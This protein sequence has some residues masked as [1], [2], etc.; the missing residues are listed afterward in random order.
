MD[1]NASLILGGLNEAQREAVT[2]T[3]GPLL[4]VAGPGTGKTL[5]IVRRTAWLIA[6]GVTPESILAVT[7]TNRS[8]R[9]MKERVEVLLGN[10]GA[11]IFIGTLH[12]LGLKIIKKASSSDFTL[13]SREEQFELIKALSKKTDIRARD[14]VERISRIKNHIDPLDEESKGL[15]DE[16][17]AALKNNRAVDFDDLIRTPIDILERNPPAPFVSK[18]THIMIDEYQDINPAQYRLLR[19]LSRTADSIC[20]IGDADQAIYGFRGADSSSFL[21][22]SSDFNNA[23][24]V[25]LTENYRSSGSILSASHSVISRNQKRIEKTIVP[26]LGQGN[27]INVL[28]LPD[29]RT[30]GEFIVQEIE[31]RI[32]GTSHY[33]MSHAGRERG[34][35]SGAFSFSDF[36]VLYRTNAQAKAIEEVFMASGIPYQ[37]VGR[38]SS[39]QSKE[40]EETIA[41]LHSLADPHAPESDQSEANEAKLLTSAD[42]FDPRAN[43]V[44]LATMHTAKGLEFRVVFMA[45]LEDG[46]VPFTTTKSDA[47]IEEERR[48][49]Y[50]GMT[51]AKEELF[52]LHVRSRFL[53]G[54]R[55]SPS[56]S[57]F[58][59]EIPDEIKKNI[60]VPDKVKKKKEPDKQMGLF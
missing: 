14:L 21:S 28:S 40:R 8:A 19:L 3:A 48:L 34:G 17:Q 46:L 31:A 13:Y 47:D 24:T 5:T 32:G 33:Q 42:F 45:G 6:Q 57:P 11:K 36:S 60:V 52:L 25:T 44:T 54:Q 56:P 41:Y 37:V 29:E 26:T 49:F 27:R 16:Y 7:F 35:S 43:A 2:I 50:V 12:L 15:L 10:D 23:A 9:E 51:R 38:K 18:F 58:L 53:Y 1:T 39:L 55:L 4:I 22:F 30:E 20:A 59:G